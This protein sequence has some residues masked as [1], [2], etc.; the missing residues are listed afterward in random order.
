MK[1]KT[2][3]KQRKAARTNKKAAKVSAV[4]ALAQYVVI[5]VF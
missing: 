5:S 1:T 4:V 3:T 2:Q